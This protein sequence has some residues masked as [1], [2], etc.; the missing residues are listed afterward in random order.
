MGLVPSRES[1]YETPAATLQPRALP[2]ISRAA[3]NYMYKTNRTGRVFG[4]GM[5][6]GS[7]GDAPR[8]TALL[9]GVPTAELANKIMEA[10]LNAVF[11]E[12]PAEATAAVAAS[13][14][15]RRGSAKSTEAQCRGRDAGTLALETPAAEALRQGRVPYVYYYEHRAL[16]LTTEFFPS[17]DCVLFRQLWHARKQQ[18]PRY[19]FQLDHTWSPGALTDPTAVYES[20]TELATRNMTDIQAA[21]LSAGQPITKEN[22]AQAQGQL[23]A[24][25]RALNGGDV[26]MGHCATSSAGS[27]RTRVPFATRKEFYNL[28]VLTT[29]ESVIYDTNQE[30]RAAVCGAATSGEAMRK[31]TGKAGREP[32]AEESSRAERD[33]QRLRPVPCAVVLVRRCM[34]AHEYR[35]TYFVANN[36]RHHKAS[37]GAA[38]ASSR[39]RGAA[40]ACGTGEAH[41]LQQ[42]ESHSTLVCGDSVRAAVEELQPVDQTP[43]GEVDDDELTVPWVQVRAPQ[44]PLGL[45]EL[46]VVGMYGC[47][48][49]EEILRHTLFAPTVHTSSDPDVAAD[50]IATQNSPARE[51]HVEAVLRRA[52]PHGVPSSTLVNTAFFEKQVGDKEQCHTYFALCRLF[53]H[54]MR[55]CILGNTSDKAAV[56]STGDH[57]AC[58]Q[59]SADDEVPDEPSQQTGEAS[60]ERQRA[61][62]AWQDFIGALSGG[63]S[64]TSAFGDLANCF[65]IRFSN[66]PQLQLCR[67]IRRML[68]ELQ[69]IYPAPPSLEGFQAAQR[70]RNMVAMSRKV[71]T[72]NGAGT[73]AAQGGDQ[74]AHR[75]PP[76]KCRNGDEDTTAPPRL[77]GESESSLMDSTG[78]QPSAVA[79]TD[80][81]QQH[82]GVT[83]AKRCG[84]LAVLPLSL[85][86]EAIAEGPHQLCERDRLERDGFC[87]YASHG[88]VVF[89]LSRVAVA[90]ALNQLSF[91]PLHDSVEAL[92]V[93]LTAAAPPP[94]TYRGELRP[95]ARL[96]THTMAATAADVGRSGE[97]VEDGDN[98]MRG[99]AVTSAE[100]HSPEALANMYNNAVRYS[101]C[102][103][104]FSMEPLWPIK[105][106]S[107]SWATHATAL[108]DTPDELIGVLP[109]NSIEQRRGR[110]LPLRGVVMSEGAAAAANG[111][112]NGGAAH[113]GCSSGASAP[114]QP[115]Q[116][117]HSQ[118]ALSSTPACA[119]FPVD[120]YTVSAE[121]DG[122]PFR[123]LVEMMHQEQQQRWQL[124]ACG[125]SQESTLRLMIESVD[126]QGNIEPDSVLNWSPMAALGSL[127][128]KRALAAAGCGYA[129]ASGDRSNAAAEVAGMRSMSTLSA[130]VPVSQGVVSIFVREP[131]RILHTGDRIRFSPHRGGSP[132]SGGRNSP[133]AASGSGT[134]HTRSRGGG[135][136]NSGTSQHGYWYV[137]D[138]LTTEDMILSWMRRVGGR[139]RETCGTDTKWVRFPEPVLQVLLRFAH[140]CRQQPGGEWLATGHAL[141]P[142]HPADEELVEPD[143]LQNYPDI[144][145]TR[146]FR[147]WR[148]SHDGYVYFHGVTVRIPGSSPLPSHPPPAAVMTAAAHHAAIHNCGEMTFGMCGRRSPGLAVV[149][150]ARAAF[151]PPQQQS[152][153][154]QQRSVMQYGAESQPSDVMPHSGS[155]EGGG[156]QYGAGAATGGPAYYADQAMY[157]IMG[158]SGSMPRKHYDPSMASQQLH[159]CLSALPRHQQFSQH[160]P[161]QYSTQQLSQKTQ[162]VG[163][164]FLHHTMQPQQPQQPQQY[165]GPKAHYACTDHSSM[166]GGSEQEATP[167]GYYGNS[168]SS[169]AEGAGGARPSPPNT[170]NGFH[171][172]DADLLQSNAAATSSS[173]NQQPEYQPR[174]YHSHHADGGSFSE[175]TSVGGTG[176]FVDYPDGTFY[177][178]SDRAHSAATMVVPAQVTSSFYG[179]IYNP[180]VEQLPHTPQQQQQQQQQQRYRSQAHSPFN[181][182]EPASGHASGSRRVDNTLLAYGLPPNAAGIVPP[183]EEVPNPSMVAAGCGR[184]Q[185]EAT[186]SSSEPFMM[187]VASGDQQHQQ[188]SR[189]QPHSSM[190]PPPSA[191]APPPPPQQPMNLSLHGEGDRAGHAAERRT[192]DD[193]PPRRSPTTI[194]AATAVTVSAAKPTSQTLIIQTLRGAHPAVGHR[195]P[196]VA[197]FAPDVIDPLPLSPSGG[198]TRPVMTPKDRTAE[199]VDSGADIVSDC[200][201]SSRPTRARVV[202]GCNPDLS[203]TTQQT[204]VGAQQVYQQSQQQQQQPLQQGQ[205]PPPRSPQLASGPG[206]FRDTITTDVI[207]ADSITVRVMQRKPSMARQSSYNGATGGAVA[208]GYRTGSGAFGNSSNIAGDGSAPDAFSPSPMGYGAMGVSPSGGLESMR[209]EANSMHRKTGGVSANDSRTVPELRSYRLSQVRTSTTGHQVASGRS[210]AASF[211]VPQLQRQSSMMGSS[212]PTQRTSQRISHNPYT[213]AGAL[214]ATPL[215]T[216][217]GLSIHSQGGAGGCKAGSSGP[218][219]SFADA[220]DNRYGSASDFNASVSAFPLSLAHNAHGTTHGTYY[221][222]CAGDPTGFRSSPATSQR[223][224]FYPSQRAAGDVD[225]SSRAG[226]QQEGRHESYASFYEGAEGAPASTHYS[227]IYQNAAADGTTQGFFFSMGE[228][229][230]TG[231][232]A[233]ELYGG[234]PDYQISQGHVRPLEGKMNKSVGRGGSAY[235]GVPLPTRNMH[236][237]QQQQ[238]SVGGG[239]ACNGGAYEDSTP[240]SALPYSSQSQQQHAYSPT[241]AAFQRH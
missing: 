203:S 226:Q 10:D 15:S 200:S 104:G 160:V 231:N 223:P 13:R 130:N 177:E 41:Q 12:D 126:A 193:Y 228:Y 140:T 215:A 71:G 39:R 195:A 102:A 206:S 142:L 2:F 157:S 156:G 241:S 146:R 58:E 219:D 124:T 165:R 189:Q 31:R 32:A 221:L 132:N 151:E 43:Q 201:T 239:N 85:D 234:S 176:F 63:A 147:Q 81:K 89:R 237:Q 48:T 149:S 204:R 103:T 47:W 3:E 60:T 125:A 59:T 7:A 57:A 8:P 33:C 127:R 153:V 35:Y 154:P 164:A 199:G 128:W 213:T 4:S 65:L 233:E 141:R 111:A 80:D 73:G 6:L 123:E 20:F 83:I 105:L 70:Q 27:Q 107:A 168:S 29:K 120:V 162:H 121:L 19:H 170:I 166:V 34:P 84:K 82:E 198:N 55:R 99:G 135:N 5:A 109:R 68:T 40:N 187:H 49:V 137:D 37:S 192:T 117:R 207:E 230:E 229:E 66:I 113:Q 167:S 158:G 50:S 62:P 179:G 51:A 175:G 112:C 152:V 76:L 148:F 218:Y 173:I 129:G 110:L 240:T 214:C 54:G 114:S 194:L 24:A 171:L 36:E 174:G 208:S 22:L 182:C 150:S 211:A 18:N 216:A 25:V 185:E 131:E 190:L 236:H 88:L 42:R 53:A 138:N 232:S 159:P 100:A 222:R 23:Q 92:C 143:L 38:G 91:A 101:S 46:R 191:P 9:N 118:S 67:Q 224:S 78:A 87:C 21:C 180:S 144:L 202:P 30:L 210:A 79:K 133:M 172:N 77:Q 115:H 94:L 95:P 98:K 235:G 74:S 44:A 178:S 227:D 183:G 197:S 186:S 75:S 64:A 184:D 93:T 163:G 155:G 45:A 169:A 161:Q 122:M 238:R 106:D 134:P 212:S 96:R 209:D 1:L 145:R 16:P 119:L 136:A 181:V 225:D 97:E 26:G 116:Q 14:G 61:D 17:P 196:P 11:I 86:P 28:V 139:A 72:S 220:L 217:A 205:A 56:T 90:R 188:H 69:G 108:E 52:A